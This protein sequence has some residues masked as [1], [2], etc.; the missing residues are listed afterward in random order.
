MIATAD[1]TIPIPTPTI[2]SSPTLKPTSTITPSPTSTHTPT[3][4]ATITSTPSG[5]TPLPDWAYEQYGPSW[6]PNCENDDMYDGVGLPAWANGFCVPGRITLESQF[7]NVPSDFY[8]AAVCYAP[9]VMENQVKA[10]GYDPKKVQGVALPSCAAIHET[11]WLRFSGSNGW[12]G[13]FKVVDCSAR[14]HLYYHMVGMGIVVEIGFST[15]ERFGIWPGLN[16]VDVHIGSGKP[17]A[18][19]GLYLPYWWLENVLEWELPKE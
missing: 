17:G 14:N 9:G 15:A 13:P 18:W 12:Q 19:D 2:T 1:E 10:K 6:I 8:G 11:V 7:F 3:P 16:R 5:P 4:T